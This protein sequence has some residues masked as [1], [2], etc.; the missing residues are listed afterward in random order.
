MQPQQRLLHLRVHA[1]DDELLEMVLISGEEGRADDFTGG[2]GRFLFQALRQIQH[3]IQLVEAQT[4]LGREKFQTVELP[5]MVAGGHHD[6]PIRAEAVRQNG[7]VHGG[8]GA[9]SVIHRFCA[10][11]RDA[12]R[13]SLQQLRTRYAAVTPQRDTDAFHGLAGLAGDIAGKGHAQRLRHI[14]GE[15]RALAYSHAAHVG[16][17]FELS[18]IHGVTLLH[19]HYASSFAMPSSAACRS[20]R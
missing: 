1:V 2:A 11:R 14:R 15:G 19:Y 17:A 3:L 16:P 5:G 13:R 20:S 10:R 12:L 7:H 4:A 9:H 18:V 6:G 8:R